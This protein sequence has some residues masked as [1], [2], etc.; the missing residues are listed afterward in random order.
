MTDEQGPGRLFD[1]RR[2]ED[3]EHT[4]GPLRDERGLARPTR[5]MI[6]DDDPEMRGVIDAALDEAPG[7]YEVVGECRNGE[8]AIEE[9]RRLRPDVI[10]LDL[11]MPVMDGLEALPWL[12]KELPDVR[13]VICSGSCSGDKFD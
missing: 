10:L 7:R 9:A 2:R 8:E 11:D 12:K 13:I 4:H 1:R 5:I 3:P 6:V